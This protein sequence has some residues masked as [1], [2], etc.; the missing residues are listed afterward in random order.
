MIITIIFGGVF[1]C[2]ILF[3]LSL[4][5]CIIVV[6]VVMRKSKAKQNPRKVEVVY[7]NES[8]LRKDTTS[9][10]FENRNISHRDDMETNMGV[11]SRHQ[12][13]NYKGPLANDEAIHSDNDDGP[14]V[15]GEIGEGPYDCVGDLFTND[16][17]DHANNGDNYAN[18]GGEYANNGG[19]YANN[20]GEYANNGGEYA[21]NE[22]E[23]ANNGGEYANNEG[24]YANNEGDYISN[25]GEYDNYGGEYDNYRGDY[26][27]NRGGHDNDEE[28]V[29][30]YSN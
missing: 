22:G 21:N 8:H 24:D 10:R 19:E 14:Y 6:C 3:L 9:N 20:G 16:E 17:D 7:R 1:I 25:E 23:Y 11:G 13:T 5:I 4:I 12:S 15:I 29:Y 27:V 18:N 26:A 28:I 2:S 30:E